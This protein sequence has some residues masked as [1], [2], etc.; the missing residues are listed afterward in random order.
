MDKDTNA[1]QPANSKLRLLII[2]DQPDIRMYLD[3]ILKSTYDVDMVDNPEDALRKAEAERYDL[4][5]VDIN[6]KDERD[7]V[8]LFHAFRAMP[9]YEHAPMIACTA[10]ALASERVYFLQTGFDEY[11]S[12]PFQRKVLLDT[13]ERMASLAQIEGLSPPLHPSA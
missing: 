5:L 13:L 2:E 7:G 8:D 10:Y 9:K 1:T 4:F 11:V 6:L 3:V 12:K